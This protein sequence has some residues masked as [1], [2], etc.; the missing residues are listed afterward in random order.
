V[1]GSAAFSRLYTIFHRPLTASLLAGRALTARL[2]RVYSIKMEKS[3]TNL[4]VDSDRRGE[5]SRRA[6]RSVRPLLPVESCQFSYA[7]Q[8]SS[9]VAASLDLL[10]DLDQLAPYD[11]GNIEG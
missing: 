4:E 3:T 7:S 10:A 5:R 1:V 8:G 6:Q 2:N 9:P 11:T